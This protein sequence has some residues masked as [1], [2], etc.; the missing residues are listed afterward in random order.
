MSFLSSFHLFVVVFPL[1]YHFN[2]GL[3]ETETLLCRALPHLPRSGLGLGEQRVWPSSW[4]ENAIQ[5][6]ADANCSLLILDSW[7]IDDEDLDHALSLLP[8][9]TSFFLAVTSLSLRQNTLKQVPSA[10]MK[11]YN[12][13]FLDLSECGLERVPSGVWELRF[14][15]ELYLSGNNIVSPK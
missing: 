14:L 13:R 12:L 3:Q 7:R 6:A 1:F 9:S 8:S 4:L 11:C 15:T 5:I 10:L 2:S